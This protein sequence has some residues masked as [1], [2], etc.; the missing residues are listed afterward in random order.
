MSHRHVEIVIGRLITD[1][2]FLRQ[3]TQDPS[4][5]LEELAEAGLDL[6]SA[7]LIALRRTEVTVWRNVASALD[8]RLQKA[9]LRPHHSES[10]TD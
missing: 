6:T 8:P 5:W 3:F 9:S 7:E 1:E 10:P 2:E 4:R